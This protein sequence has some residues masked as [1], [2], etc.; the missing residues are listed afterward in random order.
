MSFKKLLN[1]IIYIHTFYKNIVEFFLE[2][3]KDEI[4]ILLKI[5]D[6]RNKRKLNDN[7]IE[8]NYRLTVTFNININKNF[9]LFQIYGIA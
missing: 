5:L 8:K 7:E 3:Y 6:E 1:S 2:V 4:D 9:N